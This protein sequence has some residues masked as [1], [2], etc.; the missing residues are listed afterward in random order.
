MPLDGAKMEQWLQD[1]RGLAVQ[2]FAALAAK[3]LGP[4]GLDEP[5]MRVEVTLP[6]G[7]ATSL[8]VSKKGPGDGAE[9]YG[10]VSGQNNV[11][12]LSEAQVSKLRAGLASFEKTSSPQ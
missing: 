12:V 7:E 9:R 8:L 2:R 3:D 5:A 11:F 4:Y 10:V 6:S 1:L